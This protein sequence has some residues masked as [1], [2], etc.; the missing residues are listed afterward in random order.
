MRRLACVVVALA[1]VGFAE[2][3]TQAEKKPTPLISII[4]LQ[5]E[6]I[7]GAGLVVEQYSVHGHSHKPLIDVFVAHAKSR[8]VAVYFVP[9]TRDTAIL[10]GLSGC[11][12]TPIGLKCVLLIDSEHEPNGMLR[13][14]IHELAH[15]GHG[16][17]QSKE[18]AEVFAETVTYFVLRALGLDTSRESMSYLVQRTTA[19]QRRMV[20]T[21]RESDIRRQ[22]ARLVKVGQA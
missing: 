4:E 15:L 1:L 22:I 7:V 18:E 5:I 20:L 3:H 6:M 12:L 17:T 10:G 9:I 2:Q 11:V 13:I 16:K 14:L 19:E 8:G 21:K